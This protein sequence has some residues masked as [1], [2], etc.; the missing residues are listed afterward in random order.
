MQQE[1][2]DE[3]AGVKCDSPRVRRVV[4]LQRCAS[5]KLRL[6]AV[7]Q[8]WVQR[9]D[10]NEEGM[11]EWAAASD[12]APLKMRV[13]VVRS[14]VCLLAWAGRSRSTMLFCFDGWWGW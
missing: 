13:Q 10:K 14:G 11:N 9:C 2:I 6:G 7:V 4:R 5:V 12:P 3:L 1:R 8:Q